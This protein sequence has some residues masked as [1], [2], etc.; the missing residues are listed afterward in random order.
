MKPVPHMEHQTM[1][2][3]IS[4]LIVGRRT[5][6]HHEFVV[7]GRSRWSILTMQPLDLTLEW[8]HL[9]L[10]IRL[11]HHSLE[12]LRYCIRPP[13]LQRRLCIE[14]GARGRQRS[15]CV[16]L[17]PRYIVRTR[18]FDRPAGNAVDLD[19][20]VVGEIRC[21]ALLWLKR[22]RAQPELERSGVHAI[23]KNHPSIPVLFAIDLVDQLLQCLPGYLLL[24]SRYRPTTSHAKVRPERIR[25]RA[26]LRKGNAHSVR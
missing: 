14:I 3:R 15:L 1:T 6:D 23:V 24:T 7:V 16:S 12:H 17:Q 22:H 26:V 9:M 2:V 4:R 19:L 11:V 13:Q 21:R 10:C 18:S 20:V 5:S 25:H 8:H